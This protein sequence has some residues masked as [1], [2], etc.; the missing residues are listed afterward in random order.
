[1]TLKIARL[2]GRRKEGMKDFEHYFFRIV[3]LGDDKKYLIFRRRV[4]SVWF[5]LCFSLSILRA[6]T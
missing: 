6:L 2:V 1:M 3:L 5:A 4:F